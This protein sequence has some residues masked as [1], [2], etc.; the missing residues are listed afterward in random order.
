MHQ[1]SRYPLTY[2]LRWMEEN[3]YSSVQVK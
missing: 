2:E 3:L 1:H